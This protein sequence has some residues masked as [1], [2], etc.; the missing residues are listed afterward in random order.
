MEND[1]FLTFDTEFLSSY[2]VGLNQELSHHKENYIY[3][4]PSFFC[5]FAR[6]YSRI[7]YLMRVSLGNSGLS[8]QVERIG[9]FQLE[10]QSVL[11]CQTNV[12]LAKDQISSRTPVQ[13]SGHQES[14]MPII[15]HP[16]E[17][18]SS[19]HWKH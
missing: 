4:K 15:L 18:Y 3:Q 12:I 10:S 1:S 8:D 11:H 17:G 16:F 6:L 7:Q 2:Q 14:L 13:D 19:Q 5:D 9:L